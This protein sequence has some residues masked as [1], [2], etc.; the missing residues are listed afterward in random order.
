RT[1]PNRAEQSRTEPNRAEQNRVV[2]FFSFVVLLTLFFHIFLL[3]LKH[4]FQLNIYFARCGDLFADFLNPVRYSVGRNPYFDTTI[5]PMHHN[6]PGVFYIFCWLVAR[7]A[8]FDSPIYNASLSDLWGNRLL[9]LITFYYLMI[10]VLLMINS[11]SCLIKKFKVNKIIIFPL[12]LSYVTLYSIERANHVMFCSVCLFYFVSFYDSEDKKLNIFACLCLALAASLKIF[13][14][15]FGFLY[16]EKKQYKQIIIS[17]VM[18]L[19]LFFAPFFFFSN[20]IRNISRYLSN[21]TMFANGGQNGMF[22]FIKKIVMCAFLV[23][24]LFQKIKFHRYACVTIAV[25]GLSTNAGFYTALYYFPLIVLVFSTRAEDE[26]NL[27]PMIRYSFIVYF[28]FLLM[29]LQITT[30]PN[31]YIYQRVWFYFFLPYLFYVFIKTVKNC[32]KYILLKSN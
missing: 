4:D 30:L 13:P 24:S 14:V 7:I 20:G 6:Q 18:T 1:E 25:L 27:S 15:L 8:N 16:F 29:P 3:L 2:F 28:A 31:R 19:I 21:V 9:M 23:L 32:K 26:Y 17:A 12:M 11:L 5:H 22:D 10:N